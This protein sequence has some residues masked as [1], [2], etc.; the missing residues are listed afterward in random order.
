[1]RL[2]VWRNGVCGL[3]R[4]DFAR[5]SLRVCVRVAIGI[6]IVDVARRAGR[7]AVLRGGSRM[8]AAAAAATAAAPFAGTSG[9]RSGR[10]RGGFCVVGSGGFRRFCCCFDI[11]G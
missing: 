10:L 2:R 4:M 6:L 7:S 3:W 1:M 8:F 9:I 11:R 5:R